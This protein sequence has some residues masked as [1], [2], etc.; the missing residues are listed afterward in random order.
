MYVYDCCR[1]RLICIAFTASVYL[2]VIFF[3]FCTHVRVLYI[4]YF[5]VHAGLLW[6]WICPSL[7]KSGLSRPI[8]FP[9]LPPDNNNDYTPLVHTLYTICYTHIGFPVSKEVRFG[10]KKTTVSRPLRESSATTV[11]V[12]ATT[13]VFIFRN[14]HYN[15]GTRCNAYVRTRHLITGIHGRVN[16]VII[17]SG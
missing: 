11:V 2:R 13:M 4:L 8:E 1:N 10:N 12:Y 9:K 16:I 6:M 15:N 7:L 5:R 17:G 3:F 14:V